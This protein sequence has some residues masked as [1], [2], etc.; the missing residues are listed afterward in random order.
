MRA[1]DLVAMGEFGVLRR[2][3]VASLPRGAAEAPVV[4]EESL[5]YGSPVH[6]AIA[7]SRLGLETG[8][9]G[10]VG[11]DQEGATVRS[12]LED[13]R[14]DVSNVVSK[15]G[16]TA[17]RIVVTDGSEGITL[18]QPGTGGELQ[19][20]DVN[21]SAV[22]GARYIYLGAAVGD[23]QLWLQKQL[24]SGLNQTRLV[25]NLNDH[26]Q[27]GMEEIR[28][29]LQR[30]D[31]VFVGE[32]S[33][34]SSTGGAYPEGAMTLLGEGC[35]MVAVLLREGGASVVDQGG[36]HLARLAIPDPGEHPFEAFMAGV[37]FGLL[38]D[39]APDMTAELGC[40]MAA[41]H[42]SR[43]NGGFPS[44]EEL[45][46]SMSPAPNGVG[47]VDFVAEP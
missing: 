12:T 3:V 47:G 37:L 1:T 11:N 42:G 20:G 17:Q 25:I 13:A 7:L 21:L 31:V 22:E 18:V 6:L 8:L 5:L 39:E 26:R 2:L 44:A 40:R 28:A 30:C 38:R 16:R 9:I 33:L 36:E 29:I 35:R 34:E 27:R 14:V 15:R 41:L 46:E 45:L 43:Q 32:D 4:E 24:I 10:P 19:L 23:K